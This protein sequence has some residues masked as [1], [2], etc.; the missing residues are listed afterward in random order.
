MNPTINVFER[1]NLDF[2][3]INLAY[4]FVCLYP[5]NVKKAGPNCLWQLT[6]TPGKVCGPKCRLL[7]L[8][9]SK[10]TNLF[11]GDWRKLLIEELTVKI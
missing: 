2:V 10:Y 7:I 11:F 5:I 3:N 9:F 1:R 6:W 4:L 8:L